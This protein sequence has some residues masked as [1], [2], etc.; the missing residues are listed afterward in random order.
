MGLDSRMHVN[1]ELK[2][3]NLPIQAIKVYSWHLSA[4][5][6][7]SIKKNGFCFSI[8]VGVISFL[9]YLEG[10]RNTPS[11]FIYNVITFVT[12][13]IDLT[14]HSLFEFEYRNCVWEAWAPKRLEYV[15]EKPIWVQELHVVLW[16]L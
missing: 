6:V 7:I 14:L 10:K 2:H 9:V 3:S 11:N 12:L 8:F 1:K 13:L 15:L 5:N 16:G 4:S